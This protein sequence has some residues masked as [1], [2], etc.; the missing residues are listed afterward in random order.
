MASWP[1]F[2]EAFNGGPPD[3][4]VTVS[5]IFEPYRER[6]S[7]NIKPEQGARSCMTLKGNDSPGDASISTELLQEVFKISP[8]S[9]A[10]RSNGLFKNTA[11]STVLKNG[12]NLRV[13][14]ADHSYN[15]P[16]IYAI[17]LGDL[18]AVKI[19]L[20]HGADPNSQ[21]IYGDTPLHSVF[22]NKSSES[23]TEELLCYGADL[24]RKND[25]GHTPLHSAAMN[26]LVGV[27]RI[28]VLNGA[29]VDCQSFSG[30]TP[31]MLAVQQDCPAL[32]DCLLDFGAKLGVTDFAGHNALHWAATHDSIR[33]RLSLSKWI[34]KVF[35]LQQSL[36]V[37]WM[38]D[39]SELLRWADALSGSEGST[40]VGRR[41]LQER[42]IT[43]H[44]NIIFSIHDR[45]QGKAE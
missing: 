14:D 24:R 16:L 29:S 39:E 40:H 10:V 7:K 20:S 13:D 6:I 36:D 37:E 31:L 17:R 42:L 45:L 18:D 15:T 30:A 28:L 41:L 5:A 11:I 23:I 25:I 8:L 33:T 19:L 1:I 26:G 21:N 35:D 44:S 43:E 27:A 2:G 3:S 38:I 34:A 22:W 4:S 32:L 12:G 9:L